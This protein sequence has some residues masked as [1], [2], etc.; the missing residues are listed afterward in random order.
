MFMLAGRGESKEHDQRSIQCDEL[1]VA[2]PA[3]AF[4]EAGSRHGRD[5]VDHELA[6]LI[7]SV[8]L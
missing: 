2:E 3:E 1:V 5:L 6:R 8:L 4:A 7:E